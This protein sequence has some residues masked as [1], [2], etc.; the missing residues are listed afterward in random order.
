[1]S[2]P[3]D[4]PWP[5]PG[6]RAAR[7]AALAKAQSFNAP[8]PPA[9]PPPDWAVPP[10]APADD[11]ASDTSSRPRPAPADLLAILATDTTLMRAWSD[12]RD[13]DLEDGQLSREARSF[14]FHALDELA[15]L[16]E[17]LETGTWSPGPVKTFS[18]IVDGDA[19]T[20]TVSRVRD[21]VVER[22]LNE[23]MAEAI[24][25]G[26]SPFSFAFRRGMGVRSALLALREARDAGYTHVARADVRDAFGSVPRR[27][28]MEALSQ[29]LPDQRIATLVERLLTRLDDDAMSGTGI[30]QGS[31]ISPM[32]LN[33]YLDGIDRHLL[34]EGLLPIRY[35]DDLAVPAE[36]EAQATEILALLADWLAD[37]GLE[38]NA[39][40]THVA[41]FAAG[42]TFLGQRIS[43]LG[44]P[45]DTPDQVHPRRIVVYVTG[46]GAW[47]KLRNG[48][49]RVDRDGETITSI[50]LA[51]VQALVLG[52]R[53]GISG[54]LLRQA[55][56]SGTDVVMVNDHG[57][58]VGRVGRRRGVDVRIRQ[59]QYRAVDDDDRRMQLAGG[60]AAAKLRNM[61]IAVLRDVRR[62]R[63]RSDSAAA[64]DVAE[65]LDAAAGH[66]E[67]AISVPALMGVEGAGTRQYFRW[68]DDELDRS[69][70]FHGRN[71]R[72]PH[73][74]VNA[75]LSFGY[76]LLAAELVTACELA[77][78]DPDLGFLHSPRW[79]RPS[80]AL[81]VMEQWRPVLVDTAVLTLVR[82]GRIKP[83]DFAHDPERGCRMN[84]KSKRAFLVAYE[85]RLLTRASSPC[86]EGRHAYRE[87]LTIHARNL[88]DHLMHGDPMRWY[89]WR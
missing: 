53:A 32:L 37:L 59:E 18:D 19:R 13:A 17:E 61:R 82:S 79:G 15:Q 81:D 5:P 4:P 25:P 39:R 41:T 43:A 24:D 23:V 31:A 2:P 28:A 63:G 11:E 30:P 85:K 6:V 34:D 78:L 52:Q 58:Y 86:V 45:A 33:V 56:A 83:D 62:K 47:A 3:D 88:A 7:Q 69:W 49:V 42:V 80:L 54:P 40:K 38:L 14:D 77:G 55:V 76:T 22:A 60:M 87:L 35:A 71:R 12:V 9:Q 74:P 10:T 8:T 64:G 65:S 29:R 1:M 27:R 48:H 20:F 50:P 51:R 70:G 21:R 57:G 67:R 84:D 66:A 26:L 89:A 75:M 68:I 73:D 36:S 72:P 16:R 46:E 44:S